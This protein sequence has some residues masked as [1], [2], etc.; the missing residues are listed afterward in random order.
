MATSRLNVEKCRHCSKKHT[1]DAKYTTKNG[2][3]RVEWTCP[4]TGSKVSAF[5]KKP[6]GESAKKQTS[7]RRRRP[8]RSTKTEGGNVAAAKTRTRGGPKSISVS[9]PYEVEARPK[10]EVLWD[11]AEG[12]LDGLLAHQDRDT[13]QKAA[14]AAADAAYREAKGLGEEG[15]RVEHAFGVA[16]A[17]VLQHVALKRG[18]SV[19][20]W[21]ALAPEAL[22]GG[23]R[24]YTGGS[25]VDMV[26]GKPGE[27]GAAG[28][29]GDIAEYAVGEVYDLVDGLTG[30]ALDGNGSGVG[31]VVKETVKQEAGK[32]IVSGLTGL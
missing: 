17:E 30:G 1:V 7:R 19:Q 16:L 28:S 6:G 3:T 27:S 15:D 18:M 23:A 4:T 12:L 14:M 10:T 29:F 24:Q 25:V 11:V 8:S 32:A 31:A 5:A 21:N 22:R 20:D 13:P 26:V 9:M 2:R